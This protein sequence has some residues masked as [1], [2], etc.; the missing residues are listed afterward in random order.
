GAQHR[1]APGG[2]QGGSPGAEEGVDV[3][4]QALR[5]EERREQ[6]RG[7]G[8]ILGEH[9]QRFLPGP[10]RVDVMPARA[11]TQL[12]LR[13]LAGHGVEQGR[14]LPR[15]PPVWPRPVCA[16]ER[17]PWNGSRWGR[18]DLAILLRFPGRTVPPRR[19]VSWRKPRIPRPCKGSPPCAASPCG[20][21]RLLAL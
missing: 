18:A 13:R 20:R 14:R 21:P 8:A 4:A 11:E 17:T 5:V 12:L 7:P 2:A 10:L 6:V 3:M 19:H 1:A 16:H 15:G 9:L